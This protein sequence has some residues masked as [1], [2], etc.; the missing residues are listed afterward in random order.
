MAPSYSSP[1]NRCMSVREQACGVHQ[2]TN[3]SKLTCTSSSASVSTTCHSQVSFL[4]ACRDNHLPLMSE[5]QVLKK[6]TLKV[7]SHL[8]SCRRS[9]TI[10]SLFTL[11]CSTRSFRRAWLES[12]RPLP[13]SQKMTRKRARMKLSLLV[14][15]REANTCL[16]AS[17]SLF[18]RL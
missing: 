9:W 16:K 5:E 10:P 14:A 18:C 2:P 3:R 4:E 17:K 15:T 8:T 6:L 13:L 12:L 7:T 1:S 11:A